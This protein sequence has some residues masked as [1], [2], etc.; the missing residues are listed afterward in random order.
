MEPPRSPVVVH[1]HRTGDRLLGKRRPSSMVPGTLH[2][3]VRRRLGVSKYHSTEISEGIPFT[4]VRCLPMLVM[5]PDLQRNLAFALSSM[6][7]CC[8][9]LINGNDDDMQVFVS[10]KDLNC[11]LV[12]VDSRSTL[13]CR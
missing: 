9:E 5:A 13:S 7:L 2:F 6:Y 4:W 8:R 11:V 10:Y 3:C 1:Q 12:K